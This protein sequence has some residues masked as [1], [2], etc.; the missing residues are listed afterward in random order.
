MPDV[1]HARA[2]IRLDVAR[3]LVRVRRCLRPRGRCSVTRRGRRGEMHPAEP[4]LHVRPR[5]DGQARLAVLVPKHLLDE[6]LAVHEPRLVGLA[7]RRTHHLGRAH[8]NRGAERPARRL[9]RGRSR[10]RGR[11]RAGRL[12]GCRDDEISRGGHPPSRRRARSAAGTWKTAAPRRC[13]AE[14]RRA[15]VAFNVSNDEVDL[16]GRMCCPFARRGRH[17]CRH[18]FQA[19]MPTEIRIR[20]QRSRGH[21]VRDRDLRPPQS[22]RTTI[23]IALDNASPNACG[24]AFG[25]RPTRPGG[26][27]LA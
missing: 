2:A 25:L 18:F 5:A 3:E 10:R 17:R 9:E 24:S 23:R 12:F 14:H 19:A 21:V 13:R 27:L 7:S 1:R 16:R 20:R 22:L 26:A 15:R 6:P 11:R 8:K 4:M